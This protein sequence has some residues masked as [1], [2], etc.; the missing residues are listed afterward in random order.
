M[1]RKEKSERRRNVAAAEGRGNPPGV[2]IDEFYGGA[3]SLAD[4]FMQRWRSQVRSRDRKGQ[5]L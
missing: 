5:T 1:K 2:I 4:D 3:V